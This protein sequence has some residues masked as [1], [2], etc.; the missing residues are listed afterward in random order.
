M[1]A[2]GN[3]PTPQTITPRVRKRNGS[4]V[5]QFSR[6]TGH[7]AGS[8]RM[9]Q[10]NS[11]LAAECG[12]K[13]TAAGGCLLSGER[14]RAP[15]R[16]T[17]CQQVFGTLKSAAGLGWQLRECA[18]VR[19]KPTVSKSQGTSDSLMLYR[20]ATACL[21]MST[22]STNGAISLSH[23]DCGHLPFDFAYSSIRFSHHCR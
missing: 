14:V 20:A 21:S 23:H 17:D 8:H 4:P 2:P 10:R 7:Q 5:L 22:A 12:S 16:K 19:I 9:A 3:L 11:A 15:A 13:A 1:E 18:W 6:T